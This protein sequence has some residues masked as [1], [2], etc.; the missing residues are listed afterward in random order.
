[1]KVGF[2]VALEFLFRLSRVDAF[3]DA[4]PSEISE[5]DLHLTDSI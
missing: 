4:K 3:E 5:T 1:M 2:V